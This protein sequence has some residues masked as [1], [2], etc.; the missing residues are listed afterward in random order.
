M[1]RRSMFRALVGAPLL[2]LAVK[3]E[4]PVKTV[5]QFAFAPV[6]A[7]TLCGEA[8]IYIDPRGLLR[9]GVHLV[10]CSTAECRNRWPWIQDGV[11]QDRVSVKVERLVVEI[12]NAHMAIWDAKHH[13]DQRWPYGFRN[14]CYPSQTDIDWHMSNEKAQGI[15]QRQ[16]G[17]CWDLI[18]KE[19][20]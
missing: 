3:S 11:K 20:A 12:E 9:R 17:R 10:Q 4:T 2:P 6:T 18:A 8:V 1:N 16:I 14:C 19:L 5:E 15:L 13:A 7:C